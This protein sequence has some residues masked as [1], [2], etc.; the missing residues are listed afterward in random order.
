MGAPKV[1]K[2]RIVHDDNGVPE[3]DE[4]VDSKKYHLAIPTY[5]FEGR[6]EY[7]FAK[8]I[9]TEEKIPPKEGSSQTNGNLYEKYQKFNCSRDLMDHLK[10]SI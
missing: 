10:H 4:L 7:D 2:I 5:L 9:W 6:G 3:F 1:S 8:A